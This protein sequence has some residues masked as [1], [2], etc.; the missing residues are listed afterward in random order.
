MIITKLS[1]SGRSCCEW[2]SA[3]PGGVGFPR[4][5]VPWVQGSLISCQG[6]CGRGP[7]EG[8][9]SLHWMIIS[10]RITADNANWCDPSYKIPCGLFP[11][12]KKPS[13]FEFCWTV[14][15]IL[16]QLET[17]SWMK[18]RVKL[19]KCA[20]TLFCR[21]VLFLLVLREIICG[22]EDSKCM[23]VCM[24]VLYIVSIS[25]AAQRHFVY[26]HR[27]KGFKSFWRH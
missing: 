14:G 9:V 22:F 21:F 15:K 1:S 12:L 4:A 8:F 3:I 6:P 11:Y 10:H 13:Y 24:K 16:H 18:K 26:L 20:R 27:K 19:K 23:Y 7:S 5:R 25:T 2:T 17:W